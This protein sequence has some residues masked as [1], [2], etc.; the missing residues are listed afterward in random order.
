LIL[1][2]AALGAGALA[3]EDCAPAQS[4]ALLSLAALLLALALA[5]PARASRVALAASAF[6]LG[7]GAAGAE[8]AAYDR[9]PLRAWVA[10]PAAPAEPVELDGMAARDGRILGDRT[11]LAIDVDRVRERGVWRSRRGRV[12]VEV[13]G[14][15]AAA[16]DVLQGE[17]L[18]VFAVMSL[19]RGALTPGAFDPVGYAFREGVH[20]HGVSKSALL[21]T[22]VPGLTGPPWRRAAAR[23]RAWSRRALAREVMPGEERALLL[24]MVLGDRS[25]LGDETS[26]AFRAAGTYHVLAISGAQVALLAAVLVALLRRMRLPPDPV[27]AAVCL[28]LAFYAELV[29]GDVPVVRAAVMATVL[30][31]GRALSLDADAANLL[32]LAAGLLLVLRPSAIGDVGFQLSFGATLAIVRLTPPLLQGVRPLPLRVD[33][34]LAGSL[35]AQL[36]LAPLL[37]VHFQRLAPA[38]L[39]LN[40]AAVPL[41]GAVLLAGLAVLAAAAVAPFAAPLLGDLAWICAHALLRSADPVRWLP[42]L[43]VRVP[44]PPLWATGAMA[45]GLVA[46]ARE[47]RRRAAL[48][49]AI[50]VAGLLWGTTVAADGRLHV[51]VLDVGQGDG[52][53]VTSPA[54]RVRVV[55]A[56]PAFEGGIDAGEA[57]VGPYLRVQ[58]VRRIDRVLVTHAHPDHAGGVPFLLRSFAVAELWEGPAP[59]NDGSYR[60][61]AAAARS[62]GV[63]RRTVLRGLRETWDGVEV[64][65]LWPRRAPRAPLRVRNDDSVVVRLRFGDTTLFLSGDIEA[66]AEGA[67]DGP[68]STVLKVPHHGSRS[69]S[70]AAFLAAVGP[71]LAVLSAGFRNRHGHPHPQVVERFRLRGVELLRTDV[72]GTITLTSDGHRLWASTYRDP[73]ERLV[74]RSGN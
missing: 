42:G 51:S 60:R 14:A 67:L 44:P 6:A 69:S 28:A 30:L 73:W 18:R 9:T 23:V 1:L 27:A 53:V 4:V 70:S 36:A 63:P 29:G 22:R 64:E 26:E 74:P 58:G 65:V 16:L 49:L 24:A 31:L 41:S 62:A 61:L 8:R 20:A 21:V 7:A 34:A 54:G 2:A 56:G 47:G 13:L 17:R 15:H 25:E 72:D 50:G 66:A 59:A 39:F 37:A 71:R 35:S 45:C 11:L 40:L 55:D 32:G 33:L 5:A 57:V 48:P 43:D 68:A 19:P 10:G 38:A 46:L 12:R 3:G 52:I